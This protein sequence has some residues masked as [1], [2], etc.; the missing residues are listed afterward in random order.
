MSKK[1]DPR[2]LRVV[3][4]TREGGPDLKRIATTVVALALKKRREDA[5]QSGES[6]SPGGAAA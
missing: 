5:E 1:R 2:A 4:V 3:P 6:S